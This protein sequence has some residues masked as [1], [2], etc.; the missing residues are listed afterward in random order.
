MI[1]SG[2]QTSA[3]F[4]TGTLPLP[5]N[6]P[7]IVVAH[8]LAAQFLGFKFI[9]LEGGSGADMSVPKEI[10][11]AVSSSVSI[12]VIVGGGI[13]TPDDAQ[14]KVKAGASFIV[15]GNVLEKSN[16]LDLMKSLSKA[17]HQK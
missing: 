10:I 9:Y 1:D 17:I 8:A 4:M 11:L 3:Q 13:R 2:R 12:P 6:K 7:E 15:T 16:D 5:R 14:E